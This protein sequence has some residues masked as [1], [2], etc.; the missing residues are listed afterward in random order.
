MRFKVNL[1]SALF[2]AFLSIVSGCGGGGGAALNQTNPLSYSIS[3]MVTTSGTGLKAVTLT[4]SGAASGSTQTDLNGSYTIPSLPNGIYMVTPSKEGYTFSPTSYTVT[5]NNAD[6]TVESFTAAVPA[7]PGFNISGNVTSS[8]VALQGVLVA[9]N[10]TSAANTVTDASGNYTFTNLANGSYTVTPSKAGYTFSSLALHNPSSAVTLTGTNQAGISFIASTTS[11]LPTVF[12]ISG[13]ITTESGATIPGVTITATGG[14]A[15]SAVTDASGLY[16]IAGRSNGTYTLTPNLAGYTFSPASFAATVNGADIVM[17]DFKG[18][19]T[20]SISGKVTTPQGTGIAGL[21]VNAIGSRTYSAIT[22]SLGSYTIKGIPHGTY[23]LKVT[24]SNYTFSP[25]STTV[26]VADSNLQ[27]RSF[28]GTP[29]VNCTV[30]GWTCGSCSA[31][32]GTGTKTCTRSVITPSSNGGLACPT[33]TSTQS[34]SAP[35]CTKMSI[36]TT[37]NC[38]STCRSIR[39]ELYDHQYLG[40]FVPPGPGV[41]NVTPGLASEFMYCVHPNGSMVLES[42]GLVN[43]TAG[44]TNSFTMSCPN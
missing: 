41:F 12:T 31:A 43:F 23:S 29:I 22:D 5:V 6:I 13:K 18:I 28:T 40:S 14:T 37:G 26:D 1:L 8:G 32:C 15:A 19:P 17:Q 33:L 25:A 10:G 38:V 20:Y 3:G 39:V 27:D 7:A 4:L 44:I 21:V 11:A 16:T 35:A 34:C 42:N 24:G 2:A 9:L 30:S 36:S